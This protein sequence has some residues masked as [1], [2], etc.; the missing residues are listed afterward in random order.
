MADA[1]IRVKHTA[2]EISNY[3]MGD[4]TALEK[5]LSIWDE[6]RFKYIPY[7]YMYDE[8]SKKLLIPRGVDINYVERLFD[9][10][11]DFDYEPDPYDKV[12]IKLKVMPRDDIQRK[13]IAFLIGENDFEYTKKYAQ[14]LLN[15][16]TGEG[17]TYTTVAAI[18]LLGL[19]PIII[20]HTD[21]IRQQ[22]ISTFIKMTNLTERQICII[23]G[24]ANIKR[25][26]K[27]DSLK[28]KV[29]IV[30]HKTLLS[31]AK[32][33]SWRELGDVFKH[34]RVG[35]KVYDEAHLNFENMLHIDLNTNT[36]KTIYLTATFDRV[37]QNEIRLFNI[38]FRNLVRYGEEAKQQKRKHIIYLGV[39]YNS[40][41]P[42]DV[43]ADM[44]TYRGFNKIRYANYLMN[45]D[46]FYDALAFVLRYFKDKEGKTLILSSKID[47]VESIKDFIE[48]NFPDK[49][50]GVY[51]SKI[52]VEEKLKSREC[53]IISATPRSFGE[54]ADIPG[55]RITVMTES[56]SSKIEAEQVSGRLREYS[57]YDYTCYVE[58]VDVGFRKV[59][60]MYK[61]R[62][63]VFK[64]KCAKIL[65]ID[66]DDKI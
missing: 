31:Y 36:K 7:G 26:L 24:T 39:L 42:I 52:P 13:S 35:I 46:K 45:S 47:S 28:Y 17:K 29:Y 16:P 38:C 34:L 30:N 22:W 20:V 19:K 32:K 58:L 51:H 43:Q 18:T 60:A 23:N 14:L 9:T 61:K 56:Y 12:S 55:L 10:L 64:Q 40:H 50:V 1:K 8:E 6:R 5:K 48:K 3:N 21:I 49:T 27:D 44:F 4:S 63:S 25:L 15:L 33:H 65:T 2:I 59:Y 54:G 57:P 53:D 62:M 37:N 11:A 66:I 41:P